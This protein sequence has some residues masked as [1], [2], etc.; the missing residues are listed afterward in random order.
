MSVG[1]IKLIVVAAIIGFGYINPIV[2]IVIGGLWLSINAILL[3][4]DKRGNLASPKT[5]TQKTSGQTR[6]AVNIL[7]GQGHLAF[8]HAKGLNAIVDARLAGLGEE[9]SAGWRQS[10]D[11]CD[12]ITADYTERGKELQSKYDQRLQDVLDTL[13]ALKES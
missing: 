9:A 2:S 11:K 13:A 10:K 12:A 3:A 7:A 8:I 1:T 6:V 5:V 4:T